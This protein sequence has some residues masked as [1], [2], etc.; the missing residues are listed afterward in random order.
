METRP[1]TENEKNIT[2]QLIKIQDGIRYI[3]DLILCVYLVLMITVMPFYFQEGYVHIATDKALLCRR[4]NTAALQ[5]LL[6][7]FLISMILSFGT[8]LL[9]HKGRLTGAVWRE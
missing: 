9:E 8:F 3:M 5:G 1:Q 6:P 2:V 7:L 4:I